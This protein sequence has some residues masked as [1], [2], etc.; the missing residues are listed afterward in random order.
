[1]A[2]SSSTVFV[3][4]EGDDLPGITATN[5]GANGAVVPRPGKSVVLALKSL[6]GTGSN[7]TASWADSPTNTRPTL[8]TWDGNHLALGV[9]TA[10]WRTDPTGTARW[11]FPTTSQVRITQANNGAL[12][13]C[14]ATCTAMPRRV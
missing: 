10:R 4:V 7:I 1:M 13:N 8:A 14:G 6:A 11:S 5:R 3:I 9:Y 12:I 2:Q